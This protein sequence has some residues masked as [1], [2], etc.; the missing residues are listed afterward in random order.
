[1]KLARHLS[2]TLAL[3]AVS[4]P[5]SAAR[6]GLDA[7]NGP[8]S[9]PINKFGFGANFEEFRATVLGLGHEIVPLTS[10]LPAD[11][12]GLDAVLVAQPYDA[13][14]ISV[15]ERQA[16]RQFVEAGGGLVLVADGG[17]NAQVET[18]DLLAAEFGC[19]YDPS[20]GVNPVGTQVDAPLLHPTTLGVG[21]FGVD[22]HRPLITISSPAV[23]LTSGRGAQDTLAVIDRFLGGG[24]VVLLT[25]ADAFR[26]GTSN[27]FDIDS[28]DNRRLVET[29]V[30]FVTAPTDPILV[31]PA[32]G[33][34]GRTNRLAVANGD[35]GSL[36]VFALGV[37]GGVT[38]TG[39]GA[40]LAIAGARPVAVSTVNGLGFASTSA[41]VGPA[42]AGETVLLQA[43]ELSSCAVS[44]RVTY[45]FE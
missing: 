21:S 38:P 35:P 22:F 42:L 12:V 4:V 1:M 29:V 33:V 10:F 15:A 34:A 27:Q 7:V 6:I 18:F 30:T 40:S 8:G 37:T 5:A 39:C 19:E 36:V 31:P 45:V 16:I 9:T 11:L 3:L 41:F 14:F 23:D 32:P 26:N 25:D 24:N 13:Q 43:V 2:A 17:T 28:L 44:N 20:I